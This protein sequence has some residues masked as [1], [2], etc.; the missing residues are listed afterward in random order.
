ML[1]A[2]SYFSNAFKDFKMSY[3]QMTPQFYLN[4]SPLLWRNANE[5]KENFS[6]A[7]SHIILCHSIIGKLYIFQMY[8]RDKVWIIPTAMSGETIVLREF[9][10]SFN[11][12]K[13]LCIVERLTWGSFRLI[14][15]WRQ[16]FVWMKG[17]ILNEMELDPPF[18][19]VKGL[20]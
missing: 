18:H 2:N 9:R 1:I 19:K 10:S 4:N 7:L 8:D 14:S 20:V 15:C 12:S 17:V 3:F 5:F 16:Y 6:Q 11:F 13:W